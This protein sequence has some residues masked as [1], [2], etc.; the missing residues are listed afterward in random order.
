MT[1]YNVIITINLT[2]HSFIFIISN[3]M[4]DYFPLVTTSV[5]TFVTT[6]FENEG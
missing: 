1:N 4:S 3:I 2:N 6:F 5:T